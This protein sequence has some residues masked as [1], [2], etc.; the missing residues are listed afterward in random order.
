MKDIYLKPSIDI[1]K[2]E[3]GAFMDDWRVSI[4]DDEYEGE[5][6]AKRRNTQGLDTPDSIRFVAPLFP[7]S[8]WGD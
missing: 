3:A 4:P 6:G 2:A 8:I 5:V 1:I 7:K